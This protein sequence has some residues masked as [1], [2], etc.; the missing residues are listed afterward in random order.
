MKDY[1]IISNILLITTF[2]LAVSFKAFKAFSPGLDRSVPGICLEYPKPL[3]TYET[4]SSRVDKVY[5]VEDS[6]KQTISFQIFKRLSSTKLTY[7]SLEY[8]VAYILTFFFLNVKKR[9][10]LSRGFI[11]TLTRLLFIFVIV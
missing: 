8:F 6:L 10:M 9:N 5:F 11:F 2:K 3:L 7:S 1:Q 4:K